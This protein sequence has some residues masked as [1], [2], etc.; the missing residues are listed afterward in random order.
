MQATTKKRLKYA[1]LIGGGLLLLYF[2][3]KKFHRSS[4]GS[5]KGPTVITSGTPQVYAGGSAGGGSAASFN[6]T[7]PNFTLPAA[8]TLAPLG[9]VIT[10]QPG[11]SASGVPAY[12]PQAIASQPA[13]PN[14]ATPSTD[15]IN[16]APVSGLPFTISDPNAYN[17]ARQN[18]NLADFVSTSGGQAVVST[19]IGA[20]SNAYRSLQNYLETNILQSVE[21]TGSTQSVSDFQSG[22]L[23]EAQ[24]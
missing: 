22:T 19:E 6:P 16:T 24:K 15:H 14:I 11:T 1:A 18:P 3:W 4:G 17:T 5:S 2:V 23:R 12:S 10:T 8:I 20:G 9:P 13:M 21:A 7:S